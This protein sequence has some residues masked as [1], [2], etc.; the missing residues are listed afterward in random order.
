MIVVLDASVL[1]AEL[2]RKRG[3]DLLEHPALQV[4]IA[5]EQW[6]ETRYELARRI[7][8]ISERN[9]LSVEEVAQLRKG[10]QELLAGNVIE[11]VPS[12][13]YAHLEM[14]ARRRIPRDPND[15]PVVALSLA[16]DAAIVTGDNDF[17]GCGQ[18]TWTVDTLR[19]ELADGECE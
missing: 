15:W 4:V 14:V 9:K 16:L 18:R 8:V 2:L 17:L 10:S 13:V 19:A 12:A 1:V 7:A 3:R 6:S 5:E 11:V